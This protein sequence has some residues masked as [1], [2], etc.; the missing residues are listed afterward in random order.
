[1]KTTLRWRA[2]GTTLFESHLKFIFDIMVFF[3]IFL[4][5]GIV[6]RLYLI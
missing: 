2:I 4:L 5:L 6:H 1:M 3:Y